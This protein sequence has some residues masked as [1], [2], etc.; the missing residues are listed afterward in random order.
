MVLA[1]LAVMSI[2]LYVTRR[3]SVLGASW[4][5]VGILAS[6]A[7]GLCC[8]WQL[9]SGV[10]FLSRTWLAVFYVPAAAGVLMIYTL[11]FVGIVLGE[12][13]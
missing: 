9:P 2:A 3:L 1:P 11:L 8:L 13:L 7:A 5:Y 4:D 10:S 6:V 12:W